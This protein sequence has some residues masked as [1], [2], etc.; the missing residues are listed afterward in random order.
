MGLAQ[1]AS[2]SGPSTLGRSLNILTPRFMKYFA[3][4]TP[5]T[6]SHPPPAAPPTPNGVFTDPTLIGSSFR[7][8]SAIDL[9]DPVP[10]STA[11]SN[12]DDYWQQ[13][14]AARPRQP[15]NPGTHPL[16]S[17][18]SSLDS[19]AYTDPGPSHSRRGSGVFAPSISDTQWAARKRAHLTTRKPKFLA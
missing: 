5:R 8:R 19:V 16:L 17:R 11:P 4:R 2:T 13:I 14:L 12:P 18:T 15:G 10:P 1:S 9:S 6:P 7:T 3:S